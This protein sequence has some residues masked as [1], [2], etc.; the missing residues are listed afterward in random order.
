M[1]EKA[2]KEN[3]RY[4]K[5]GAGL[6][7]GF[8]Q[9]LALPEKPRFPNGTTECPFSGEELVRSTFSTRVAKDWEEKPLPTP[10][11]FRPSLATKLLRRRDVALAERKKKVGATPPVL[12]GPGLNETA[13]RG[14]LAGAERGTRA[15]AS[16]V[17]GAVGRPPRGGRRSMRAAP[18]RPPATRNVVC[19]PQWHAGSAR[20][21][22]AA[23][24][25]RAPHETTPRAAATPRRSRPRR[26]GHAEAALHEHDMSGERRKR[27]R[28]HS[29][30]T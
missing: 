4:K 18:V 3:E 25:D 10:T 6:S 16:R 2:K 27:A 24:E 23:Q 28:C 8:G 29:S 5:P 19:E 13:C 14:W 30:R 22:H 9:R 7:S 21:R 26:P 20:H 17:G 15:H 12:A 1:R 11:P